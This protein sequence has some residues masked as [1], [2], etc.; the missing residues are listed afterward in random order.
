MSDLP[1]TYRQR[2]RQDGG[3]VLINPRTG[4]RHYIPNGGT[5]KWDPHAKQWKIQSDRSSGAD[6]SSDNTATPLH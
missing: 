6:D 4:N 3:S 1:T 5:F 2:L